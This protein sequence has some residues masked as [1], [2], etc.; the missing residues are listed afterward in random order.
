MSDIRVVR[1]RRWDR[2]WGA[3]LTFAFGVVPALAWLQHLVSSADADRWA[4]FLLGGIVFPIG[5]VDGL[6]IWLE[7]WH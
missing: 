2:I 6:G 4:F 3:W 5:I 1:A 7:L